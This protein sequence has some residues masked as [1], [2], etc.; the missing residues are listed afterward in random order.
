MKKG[1]IIVAT[2]VGVILLGNVLIAAAQN[3]GPS[4]WPMGPAMTE[5]G[6]YTGTMPFGGWMGGWYGPMMAAGGMHQQVWTAVAGRLGMT[7]DELTAA[8][9]NGQT[10]AQIADAKGVSLDDLKAAAIAGAKKALADLVKQGVMTQ[11][12]A[13]WMLDHMD[14]MPMF[15]FGAG[16][17]PGFG[18]CHGGR[19][20]SG[21]PGGMMNG[22]PG[23]PGGMM[24]GW[25]GGPRWTPPT[26]SGSNG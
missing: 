11:E 23:V 6:V 20:G 24:N 18:S 16:F 4:T 3:G 5:L 14:D 22:R 12:Q 8:V 2:I 25:R 26:G 9:Q 10:I 19:G 13:G 15:N 21:V 1:L 7:Y 17:G